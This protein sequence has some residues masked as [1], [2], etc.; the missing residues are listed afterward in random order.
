MQQVEQLADPLAK[1]FVVEFTWRTETMSSFFESANSS[2]SSTMV[3][4]EYEVALAQI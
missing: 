4:I 3:K 2:T 1:N